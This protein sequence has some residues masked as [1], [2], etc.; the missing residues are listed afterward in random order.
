MKFGK[1]GSKRFWNFY[2]NTLRL[3]P[4]NHRNMKKCIANNR[5]KREGPV[6]LAEPGPQLFHQ[7]NA[8][9]QQS[10]ERVTTF[11][12]PCD[13][14]ISWY[15]GWADTEVH[16]GNWLSLLVSVTKIISVSAFVDAD[17]VSVSRLS[18][19]LKGSRSQIVYKNKQIIMTR[20][21]HMSGLLSLI[22]RLLAYQ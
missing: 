13:W 16:F 22:T 5:L 6:V 21:I 7:L 19:P 20:H 14:E 8:A 18:L 4:Y 3:F 17:I 15:M 9:A 1:V 12:Y 2:F 11:L 10:L